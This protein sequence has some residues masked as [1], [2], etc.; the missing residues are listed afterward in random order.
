MSVVLISVKCYV[1]PGPRIPMPQMSMETSAFYSVW[2]LTQTL[3]SERFHTVRSYLWFKLLLCHWIIVLGN[4]DNQPLLGFSSLSFFPSFIS[5]PYYCI[6]SL[7]SLYS[8]DRPSK[9]GCVP[10][11]T[12]LTQGGL[13]R[14]RGVCNC[15]TSHRVGYDERETSSVGARTDSTDLRVGSSV[16]STQQI[17]TNFCTR[18][19]KVSWNSERF[20]CCFWL[21]YRL[22][23]KKTQ[24]SRHDRIL[25]K[26]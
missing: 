8:L 5:S 23:V 13:V 16:Q 24:I 1:N 22:L 2:F 3:S 11:M 15:V 14:W 25:I 19:N 18:L 21:Y 6:S 10:F 12:L 20:Y 26:F 17:W 7:R 9:N 4:S